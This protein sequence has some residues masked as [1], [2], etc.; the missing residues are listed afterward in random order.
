MNCLITDEILDKTVHHTNQYNLITH[1]NFSCKS[2][3]KLKDTTETKVFIGLL[4]SAGVFCSNMNS[5]VE[6]W[7][8][9]RDGTEKFRL[10]MNQ[11]RFKFL[12]RCIL[13]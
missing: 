6:L 8:T 1:P 3:A 11:R 13:E 10:V 5:L 4:C 9:D 12:I 2:D 7:G